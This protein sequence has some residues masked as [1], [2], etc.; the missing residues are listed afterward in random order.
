MALPAQVRR[1]ARVASWGAAVVVVAVAAV[2]GAIAVVAPRWDLAPGPACPDPDPTRWGCPFA[3]P[4]GAA[5]YAGAVHVHTRASD[6]AHAALPDTL[7]AAR[8]AGLSFIVVADHKGADALGGVRALVVDGVLVVAAAEWSTEAGHLLDLSFLAA[9]RTLSVA[10]EAVA[11]CRVRGGP[12]VAAHPTS[13]RRPWVAPLGD[14]DGLEV[15]S[16]MTSLGDRGRPPFLGLLAG[17]GMLVAW[18]EGVLWDVG[19][20][21]ASALS[22]LEK[23]PLAQGLSAFCSPD[24]HGWVPLRENLLGYLTLVGLPEELPRDPVLAS[25]GL[26]SALRGSTCVNALAGWVDGLSLVSQDGVVTARGQVR[27]SAGPAA[28]VL[29]RD[30]VEVGRAALEPGLAGQVQAPAAGGAWRAEVEVDAPGITG[31]MRRSAAVRTLWVDG[32]R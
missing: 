14:L 9:D 26:R 22:T 13:A 6:D 2:L 25:E 32:A 17:L 10:K 5:T 16:A 31:P 8:A 15:H 3:G 29:R 12:C 24:L 23:G 11:D 30:G 20:Y 18:R 1:W 4:Q 28:V 19:A 21:D 27:R 7:A